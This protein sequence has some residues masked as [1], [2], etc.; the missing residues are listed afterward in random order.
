MRRDAMKEINRHFE[1]REKLVQTIMRAD[2]VSREKALSDIAP[3][4]YGVARRARDGV[5]E[6]YD[7]YTGVK[8]GN[9]SDKLP[10]QHVLLAARYCSG[11]VSGVAAARL[12]KIG[13]AHFLSNPAAYDANWNPN[14]GFE[15]HMKAFSKRQAES[16]KLLENM[17]RKLEEVTAENRALVERMEKSQGT[18][19]KAKKRKAPIPDDED[20]PAQPGDN[21]GEA[22]QNDDDADA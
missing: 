4:E 21:S 19:G 1:D 8:S 13:C 10:S 11:V 9:V 18:P 7:T 17:M 6:A 12:A 20:K 2:K 14:A 15:R 5:R 3:G 22:S 16:E